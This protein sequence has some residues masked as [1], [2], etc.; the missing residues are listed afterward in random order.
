MPT[1]TY[2]LRPP[3]RRRA[4]HAPASPTAAALVLVS[5]NYIFEYQ[6]VELMFDRAI[7]VD[8]LVASQIQVYD[9]AFA[10]NVFNGDAGTLL[11]PDRVRVTLVPVEE[12]ISPDVELTAGAGSGIVAVDDGGTWAGVI[13]LELP[14][15]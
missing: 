13:D 5:A 9:G 14:F 6:F 7:N 3:P 8:G 1:P 15:P 2:Q 10:Q 12:W 4:H 11:A